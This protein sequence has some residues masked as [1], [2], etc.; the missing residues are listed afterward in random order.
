MKKLSLVLLVGV[1]L[2]LATTAQ[3]QFKMAIG[4]ALGLNFNIHSGADLEKSGTGVGLVIGGQADMS[5][6]KSIGLL[7]TLY[8]Y[9]NR[10]GSYSSTGSQQGVNYTVD[11]TAS[12]AYFEIEPLFKFTLSDAP[13]YFIAGPDLGFSVEGQSE[14]KTTITTP[15]YTFQGGGTS[16]TNK[17]SIKDMNARFE[18]KFG[19]GYIF[20]LSKGMRINSQFTFGYGLTNI[21]KDV[22]WK[23]MSFGLLGS[24]EFDIVK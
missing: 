9:D 23:I 3:A 14:A 1:C 12:V 6:S 7:T 15:G 21:A 20:P 24:I 2:V 13:I 11:V 22:N 10:S 17:S 18:M 4:P 8:F 16:Q 19:G 5:F